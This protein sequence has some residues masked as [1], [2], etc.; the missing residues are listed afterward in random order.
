MSKNQHLIW[1]DLEMTGLNV[2]NDKIIEIATIVTDADLN[3]IAVGPELVIHQSDE[4]LAA[5]DEWNTKQHHSTG[6]VERVKNSQITESMAE[7]QTL[8]FLQQYVP[9]GK[10][11]M[12][13]NTI[14]Q[15]RRFLYKHMPALERYFHY[16]NLDVSTVKELALRWAPDVLKSMKK[17]SRHRA[18][19]DIR[20]S[21]EELKHYRKYFFKLGEGS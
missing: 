1:I 20:D 14:C 19:D 6:L 7:Q 9:A 3:V 12:A 11:P 15:D 18:L 5:M 10:S 2:D 4:I 17:E 16:R 13:G 21:I 8:A